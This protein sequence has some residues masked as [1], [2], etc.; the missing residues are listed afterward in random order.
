MG[1]VME[2][3]EG[4]EEERWIACNV[5]QSYGGIGGISIMSAFSGNTTNKLFLGGGGGTGTYEDFS[6]D[7]TKGG[8]GGGIVFI[9]A[10]DI[11]GNNRK[12][13]ANGESVQGTTMFESAG[14]GGGG[15]TIVLVTNNIT[16]VLS[17]EAKG[18]NGG[19]SSNLNC[20][21]SGGGG[22]GGVIFSV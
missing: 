9:V 4:K 10:R 15:G 18:G 8:N 14:G 22:G 21:G 19:S 5:S 17:L 12:I 1:V 7:I 2:D 13:K 16:G 11:V 3:R 6:N 20:R